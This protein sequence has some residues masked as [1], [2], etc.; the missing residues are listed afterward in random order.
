MDERTQQLRG[1]INIAMSNATGRGDRD[2]IYVA[3]DEWN[4][5]Y[6]A[7][8][9]ADVVGVRALEE[10][11]NLED[12]LVVSGFL[13]T[14]IRNAD[15]VKIANMAQLVNVIAPIFTSEDGMFHQTIF[16]PLQLF[17]QNAHGTALDV[18]VDS[19]TFDTENFSAG[20]AE[21][22]TQQT[23]VPYL[24]V[25]A[26]YEDD[27]TVIINVVNRHKDEAI[28]TD[29]ISQTG[30]F[31]GNMVVYEVNGPD[32]KTTNGFSGEPVRTEQKDDIRVRGEQFRY[33]FPAHSFTQLI[34]TIDPD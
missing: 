9:G 31:R 17:A 2:P 32:I 30:E 22:S 12:V 8:G 24:D 10:Q 14:F 15:I 34:G 29:I 18:F 13:N 20:M 16:Y 27:G 33:T 5:W 19:D 21:A 3:W 4:V 26:T 25:S 23:G 1:L 6:R 28:S 11:Y 7:R